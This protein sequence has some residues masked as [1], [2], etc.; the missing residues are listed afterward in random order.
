LISLIPA[1]RQTVTE[2]DKR[3]EG[4]RTIIEGKKKR[5]KRKKEP[6]LTAKI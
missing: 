5:R 1:Q 6:T 3:E 2:G 4:G